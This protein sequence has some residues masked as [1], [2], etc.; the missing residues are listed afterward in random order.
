MADRERQ[1]EREIENVGTKEEKH[2]F[3]HI[4]KINYIKT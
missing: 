4:L 2:V 3:I 1:R